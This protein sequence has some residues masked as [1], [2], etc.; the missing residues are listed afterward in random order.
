MR[1]FDGKTYRDLTTEEL[2]QIE[3]EQRK[4]E[5]VEKSRPLTQEE[6]YNM[7]VTAQINNLVVDDNTALRMKDFYPEWTINVSYD[8]GFKVN[9]KNK[10]WRALQA[11][12]SLDG[13]E[14]ENA[15]SLWE[16]IN[17]THSG[18]LEDS[19]PYSGNMA[20]EKDKYYIENFTEYLCIRDTINPVYSSLADLVNIY[21]EIA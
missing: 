12:T 20:L 21:V 4:A 7:I 14:P 10:L 5:L 19:I 2:A 15:T 16:Q 13:W 3:K 1:I 8:V 6:V 17:E 11:H 9:Y 18:T